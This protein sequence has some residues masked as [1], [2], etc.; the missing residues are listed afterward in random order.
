MGNQD[1]SDIVLKWDGSLGFDVLTVGSASQALPNIPTAEYSQATNILKIHSLSIAGRS[2]RNA[3]FKVLPQLALH[4]SEASKFR[5]LL[6]EMI[7]VH[8]LNLNEKF[9]ATES[10]SKVSREGVL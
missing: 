9:V 5:N 8:L 4:N 7:F 2:Y 6:G 1:Y 3:T 10:Q